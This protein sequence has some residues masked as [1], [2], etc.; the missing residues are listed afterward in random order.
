MKEFEVVDKGNKRFVLTVT[1]TR[2]TIKLQDGSSDADQIRVGLFLARVA[3]QPIIADAGVTFRG[4]TDIPPNPK[5]P[6]LIQMVND[7]KGVK[8]TFREDQFTN[9][10]P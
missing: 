9:E 3:A 7:C 2:V 6:L 10:L 1:P 8:H 4:R 5:V